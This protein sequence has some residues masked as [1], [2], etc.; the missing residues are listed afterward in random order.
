VLA[1]LLS[2]FVGLAA[3]GLVV[4]LFFYWTERG[5]LDFRATGLNSIPGLVCFAAGISLLLWEM[6]EAAGVR[7]TVRADS[8]IAFFLA[9]GCALSAIA[10]L[11]HMKWGS[12]GPFTTDL[13]IPAF[14]VIPLSLVLLAG[15]VVH[16]VLHVMAPR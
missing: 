4:D 2:V 15:A 7:R 16:L 6:L 11:I 10:T 12:P 8:L 5:E 13:A 14:L 9:A 1:R 3:A